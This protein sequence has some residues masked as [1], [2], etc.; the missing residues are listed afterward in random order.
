MNPPVWLTAL[1]GVLSAVGPIST[2]MYLP[3]FPAIEATFGGSPGAAQ[4][5]LATWFLGLA[6]GQITQGS[7]SDRFGRR[8]PLIA[9]T[10]LYTVASVGCAIAP[11]LLTLSICRAVAAFGGSASMVV[12]RAIV[13]DLTE[14]FAAARLMSRLTLVM[15]VAPILAPTLGGLVL[16]AY[17]W[18]VI[19][20]IAAAYGA[21]C[22]V[23]VWRALPD[24][25][26]RASR[27]SLRPAELAR[28]YGA[29]GMERGFVANALCGGFAM[30]AMFAYLGGSPA[31]FEGIYRLSPGSYGAMFGGCAAGFIAASQINPLLLPRFGAVVIMRFAARVFLGAAAL[32]TVL[33][34]WGHAPWWAMAAPIWVSLSTMGFLLPNAVVGALARH[35]ERAGSASAL[36]G[37]WQ[38]CLGAASGVAG[39]VLAD[40]TARPMALLM[41]LGACCANLAQAARPRPSFPVMAASGPIGKA[42]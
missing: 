27:I 12:P 22:C 42:A 41:L 5:T 16:G 35:Q 17:S 29:I 11:D 14:G 32:L 13:R 18:H 1:L 23:L 6:V 26:P 25:L 28:R 20:W 30:A 8:L 19:F 37:T 3:A 9:G 4:I 38:V 24:T 34:F 7:L 33:A 31:V 36:R 10:A 39:G 40:G 21:L 2:D 15:G